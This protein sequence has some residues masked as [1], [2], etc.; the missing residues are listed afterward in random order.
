MKCCFI[1]F[2]LI[3]SI[4]LICDGSVLLLFFVVLI[5]MMSSVL[6]LLFKAVIF[7]N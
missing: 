1:V 3:F 4:E 7:G 6:K 5:L 2:F